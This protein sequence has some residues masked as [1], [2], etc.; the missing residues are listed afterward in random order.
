MEFLDSK[1]EV[2]KTEFTR[3][4]KKQYAKGAFNPIYYSFSDNN[5]LYD[6]TFASGSESQNS[7][8]YRIYEE[9]P[10]LIEKYQLVSVEANFMLDS[11]QI[12]KKETNLGT[13]N[14][15]QQSGSQ[16][17]LNFIHGSQES[18]SV[19]QKGYYQ[20]SSS[21]QYEVQ[22]LTKKQ[23]PN[24]ETDSFSFTIGDSQKN[25][26]EIDD[27]NNLFIQD[28]YII[29]EIEET[30]TQFLNE[31]YDVKL[32]TIEKNDYLEFSNNQYETDQNKVEYWLT[33]L[34]DKQIPD[35]IIC[36]NKNNF[37]RKDI[38]R[39]KM[40]ECKEQNEQNKHNPDFNNLGDFKGIC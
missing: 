23:V 32:R 22:Y 4:G 31:N 25:F 9:T 37:K 19:I 17:S 21:I 26:Y 2:I 29:L 18:F 5:I 7:S 3:F 27:K 35:E 36:K 30:N 24:I 12:R 10:N 1:Q 33:I 28:D 8:S 40:F 39:D 6:V 11:T 13:I 34:L 14:T 15:N 16:L 20:I 38:F